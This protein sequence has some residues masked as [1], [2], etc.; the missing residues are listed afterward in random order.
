[1]NLWQKNI[2]VMQLVEGNLF[3]SGNQPQLHLPPP[4]AF[5]LIQAA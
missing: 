3:E 2:P 4:L 1:M 5:S